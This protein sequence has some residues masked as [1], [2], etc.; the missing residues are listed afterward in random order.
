MFFRSNSLGLFLLC[1]LAIGT[2]QAVDYVTIKRGANEKELVGKI[3]VEAEDGGVLLLAP[4]GELWPIAAEDLVSKRSDE[5]EFAPL[6]RHA[7]GRQ[8][9][10]QHPGFKLHA[11]THYLIC[12]NTS[13]DYAKWVGSL[14][15]R[16]YDGFYNF[17]SKRGLK[18]HESELPLVAMVF[19]T[20]DRY[21]VFAREELGEAVGGIIGYYSLR[22]NQVTMYDLT[23]LEGLGLRGAKA[24][25]IKALLSRPEAERNVATIVHEATHQLM[26]NSGMQTRYSDIPF[27]VS[28]GLAVFFETPDLE[29]KSGW[30]KIGAVNQYNRVQFARY[31]PQRPP[32]S[33]EALL[34]DDKRFRDPTTAPSAYAEAWALNYYLLK[35]RGDDYANYLQELAKLDAL[36]ALEPTQ[37]VAMFKAAFGGDLKNIE[38][39]W[40]KY[41]R[42]VK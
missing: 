11:T 5:Q 25:R 39:D 4:D 38:S 32:N 1:W 13:P 35:V 27:W 8:L 16:L 15:E 9:L 28:E 34:T 33:L 14:Y 6:D 29:S 26:F 36:V 21:A 22:S 30:K 31:L 20:R 2:A 23:G 18:L 3:E 10:E 7:M 42:T 41:I 24:D 40:L 37:R 17:W 12:Y 19:D